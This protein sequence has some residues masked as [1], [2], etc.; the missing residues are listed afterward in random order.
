M[1]CLTPNSEDVEIVGDL[2]H[3]T[4]E[5]SKDGFEF[6][7]PGNSRMVQELVKVIRD[8]RWAVP[9]PRYSS[10]LSGPNRRPVLTERF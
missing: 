9:V 4:L 7:T 3:L 6:D 2:F 5:R 10:I 8:K 1:I